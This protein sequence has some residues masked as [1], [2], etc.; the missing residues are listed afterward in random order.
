MIGA[1]VDGA[2][3]KNAGCYGIRGTG[4]VP[5]CRVPIVVKI[6]LFLAQ[7]NQRLRARTSLVF[8]LFTHLCKLGPVAGW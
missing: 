5:K 7:T 3:L 8:Q 6:V 1:A 2:I 4:S